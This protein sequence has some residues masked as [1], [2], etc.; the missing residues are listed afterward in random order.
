MIFYRLL[1]FITFLFLFTHMAFANTLSLSDNGDETWNV[2]YISDLV[3]AG[4]QFTV[5][6][7]TVNSASGGDAAENGFMISSS[8]SSV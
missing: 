3:I 1:N 4:F 5:D 7:A 6:G 2:N 8:S